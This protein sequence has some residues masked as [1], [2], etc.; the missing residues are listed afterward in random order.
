[1]TLA[2]LAVEQGDPELAEKILYGVLEEDPGN[3]DAERLL[4]SLTEAVP[5]PEAARIA[6]DLP[7]EK[8]LALQEWLEAV[9]LAAERLNS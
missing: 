8:V 7:A 1:M 4:E 3:Q 2:R 5:Q 6:E 9:R